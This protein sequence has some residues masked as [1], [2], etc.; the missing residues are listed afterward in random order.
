MATLS[1][2]RI[3]TLLTPY[4]DNTPTPEGLYPQLSLYLDLLLRWNARTNLTAI[5]DPEEI[6]QRHFG[7]SLF[8]ARHLLPISAPPSPALLDFGSGAGFP[9]IPIQLFLPE[10]NVTLAESQNKKS[11]FLREVVRSLGLPTE[12]W[13]ERVE[14]LPPTRLF[15]IITLRAVDNMPAAIAAASS[16]LAPDGQLAVLGSEVLP[17]AI[18]ISLP[19]PS[20]GKLCFV[21]ALTG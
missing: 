6:V 20:H 12:I 10:L 7:E 8:T 15:D 4:L 21:S 9:G 13:A 2:D 14:T 5:R 17:G 1:N 11:T 19:A 16:R 3:A 18:T